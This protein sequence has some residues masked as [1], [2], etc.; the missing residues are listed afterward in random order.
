M[1]RDPSGTA[2]MPPIS[3]NMFYE[4]TI[5]G[6]VLAGHP[7]IHGITFE[8]ISI[9]CGSGCPYA[10]S[11]LGQDHSPIRDL[12]VKDVKV[13]DGR[14]PGWL[15]GGVVSIRESGSMPAELP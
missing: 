12:S 14:A 3:V 8:N 2:G 9:S 10:G 6:R 5:P 4:D 13:L 7:K 11:F 15:C 1:D